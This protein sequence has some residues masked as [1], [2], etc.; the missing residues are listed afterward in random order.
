VTKLRLLWRGVSVV[1]VLV[2]LVIAGMLAMTQKVPAAYS[3]YVPPAKTDQVS[4]YITHYLLPNIHNNIQLDEPFEV[5]IHQ[6]GIN[7]IIAEEDMLGW[8][9]PVTLSKVVISR[10][11]AVFAPNAIRLIGKV[12]I[13]GFDTVVTVCATPTVDRE[14]MLRLNL[15]YIRAGS[16]DISFLA[17]KTIKRII[18][19]HLAEVQEQLDDIQELYWLVEVLAAFMN[20]KP[21]EPIFP[22]VD[23]KYIKL[24]KSKISDN[25]LVLTF[26]PSTRRKIADTSKTDKGM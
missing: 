7:Q 17:K 23:G 8:E 15:Q 16:L 20:N 22:A 18:E 5:V 25:K 2:F 14:G 9:W 19:G 3:S 12:D 1:I 11:V 4:E 6:E 10:P 21:F 26:E 24:I 13:A